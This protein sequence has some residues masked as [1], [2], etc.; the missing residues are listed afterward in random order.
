MR[1]DIDYDRR[2]L[3]KLMLRLPALRGELQLM[4]ARDAGFLNLC[5]AFDEASTML[6]KLRKKNDEKDRFIEEEYE[7]IVAQIELEVI[8]MLAR[9]D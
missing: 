9:I 7:L 6:G 8:N 2:G 5:G 4:A 3:A 1:T